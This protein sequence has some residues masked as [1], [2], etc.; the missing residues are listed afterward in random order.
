MDTELTQSLKNP[1]LLEKL[2]SIP[3]LNEDQRIACL[4]WTLINNGLCGSFS[5]ALLTGILRQQRTNSIMV[6]SKRSLT[7]QWRTF[8]S[9]T[10]LRIFGVL[11]ACFKVNHFSEQGR[12]R[13]LRW[14]NP[15]FASIIEEM[16]NETFQSDSQSDYGLQPGLCDDIS[17]WSNLAFGFIHR[18]KRQNVPKTI[19][20]LTTSFIW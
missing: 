8:F 1:I 18:K 13:S 19:L 5:L 12:Y 10:N 16:T 20:S 9:F 7:P 11:R 4:T 17:F 6:L 3:K 14:R 2:A 15:C